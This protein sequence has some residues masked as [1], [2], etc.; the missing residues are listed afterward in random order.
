MP[1]HSSYATVNLYLFSFFSKIKRKHLTLNR[2]E[3]YRHRLKKLEDPA[4]MNS[5]LDQS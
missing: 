2:L 1:L 4:K 5:D 3:V